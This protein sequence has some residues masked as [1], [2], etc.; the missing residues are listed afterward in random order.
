MTTRSIDQ[1]DHL[2]VLGSGKLP[3]P[4]GPPGVHLLEAF[5]NLFPQ[6]NYIIRIAYPE[7][8]SLCP[9]TGQPDFA[10]IVMEYI[11]DALCVESKSFKLYMTAFRNH[12]AFMETITNT[13]LNDLC[14]LLAPRWCRVNGIFAPRGGTRLHVFAEQFK[15]LTATETA[16]LKEQVNAWKSEARPYSS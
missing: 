11:P 2:R 15:E 8:T 16:S 7:F 1:T 12:N 14:E 13:V 5:P 4:A 6:R 3:A 10:T 9:V